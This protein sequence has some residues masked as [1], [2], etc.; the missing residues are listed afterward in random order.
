[1]C[2]GIGLD[3]CEISRME[4]NLSDSRFL[5]RYFTDHEIAY[6]HSRGK[7]AVQTLAGL[8]AAREALGKS[9][10]HGIDFNLKEAEVRHDDSGQPFYHLTGELA[11]RT[12]GDRFFLSISHDGGIAAAVCVRESL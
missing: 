6:I 9:L 1:M 10:G 5:S 4:R 8:F 3:I 11:Q 2:K 7:Q 12:A